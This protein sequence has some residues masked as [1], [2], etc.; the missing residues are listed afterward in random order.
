MVGKVTVSGS[1]LVPEN[2]QTLSDQGLFVF[3][4]SAR[5]RPRDHQVARDCLQLLKLDDT[6]SLPAPGRPLSSPQFGR[7]SGA[8]GGA[9][10]GIDL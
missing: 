3:S 1:K 5:G 2:S 4:S 7:N 10:E 9:A 6:N 8:G